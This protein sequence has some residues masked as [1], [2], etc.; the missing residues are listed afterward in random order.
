MSDTQFN[1]GDK[2]IMIMVGYA[3]AMVEYW[4]YQT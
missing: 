2:V 1:V 3:D 4:V